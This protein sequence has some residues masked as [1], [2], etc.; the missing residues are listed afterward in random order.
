[1]EPD[2]EVARVLSRAFPGCR[3]EA[4]R[5]LSGGVSARAMAATLALPDG[6]TKRVVLRRPRRATL[7]E[8]RAAAA[9][10]HALLA[11]CRELGIR[12]PKPHF[13]DPE[14]GAVVLEYVEGA[15]ELPRAPSPDLLRQMA[16]ELARI[17]RVPLG[18]DFAFVSLRLDHV[19]YNLR[20]VPAEFDRELDEAGVRSA[21]SELWPWEQRNANALLHGDYWPGNLLWRDGA[22]V[23]VLDWEE[24]TLGDPLADVALTR[25]DV[26]W[27]FGETAMQDFTEYY[28]AQTAIDWSRL[29]H[30]DLVIALRPMSRLERWAPAYA[31]PPISRPDITESHLAAGHRRFVEQALVS[32]GRSRDR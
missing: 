26:L 29:P 24:P 30:W 3:I 32:L 2:A 31:P 1:M 19:A 20:N 21:L 28:C 7:D 15:P 10:E 11:R 27:A 18:D 14:A 13:L 5:E 12:A 25:L 6:T 4:I 17:H 8:S 23:A 16:T 9:I 22:L